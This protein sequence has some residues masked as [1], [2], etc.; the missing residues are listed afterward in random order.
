VVTGA[1]GLAATLG[2][3][4]EDVIEVAATPSSD[5]VASP[6]PD[7][8]PHDQSD[9]QP[10]RIVHGAGPSGTRQAAH[11]AGQPGTQA[12]DQPL[13]LRQ[14]TTPVWEF[15]FYVDKWS[16]KDRDTFLKALAGRPPIAK[17]SGATGSGPAAA[18]AVETWLQSQ[19]NREALLAPPLRKEVRKAYESVRGNVNLTSMMLYSGPVG[20][21]RVCG[22]GRWCCAGGGC[23]YD[24]P[25]PAAWLGTGDAKINDDDDRVERLV[26]HFTPAR[27]ARVGTFMVPHHG[28]AYDFGDKMARK[29]AQ[30]VPVF[31]YGTRNTYGHPT[32]TARIQA[33][34]MRGPAR[35]VTEQTASRFV[36][37]LEID[38]I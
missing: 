1:A 3:N 16:P 10:L 23:W 12:D 21:A 20:E 18:A 29:V 11:V 35:D 19:Q 30:A 9:D 17:A 22:R 27:L 34:R 31:P 4:A 13:V 28:S 8:P 14:G 2:M 32:A 15:V 33:A 36:E 6:D 24:R 38:L 25:F 5:G 37:H 26:R 7:Q